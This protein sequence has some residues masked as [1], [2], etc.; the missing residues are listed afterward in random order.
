MQTA[1]KDL[2]DFIE[3]LDYNYLDGT[4]PLFANNLKLK[5]L[6]LQA[7]EKEQI[8][9]AF[10]A[11]V[12][13]KTSDNSTINFGNHDLNTNYNKSLPIIAAKEYY[14]QTFKNDKL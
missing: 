8:E 9:N 6:E 12:V 13:S 7:K 2:E 1:L 5:V 14:L 4:L 3:N 11:G 10:I